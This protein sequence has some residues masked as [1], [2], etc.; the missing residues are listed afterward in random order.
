MCRTGKKLLLI[1]LLVTF[2]VMLLGCGKQIYNESEGKNVSKEASVDEKVDKILS[3]MSQ[4]EKIG[5]MMM[6]GI[7]GTDVNEDSL[8]MLHQYHF[9]GIILFDRNMKNKEQCRQ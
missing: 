3:S 9:G 2:A 8:F 7:H 1:F 6:I 5:Q 4:T